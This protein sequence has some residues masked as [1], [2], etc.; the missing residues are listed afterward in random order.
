MN[1]LSNKSA[2]SSEISLMDPLYVFTYPGGPLTLFSM[3]PLVKHEAKKR[4][5][6]TGIASESSR[7]GGRGMGKG[8]ISGPNNSPYYNSFSPY[9]EK[10]GL[11]TIT[12]D[13]KLQRKKVIANYYLIV[14][15]FI[16]PDC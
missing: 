16:I 13:V 3:M 12:F 1:R 7:A 9:L 5:N 11:T 15:L 6:A 8:I 10:M 14:S 2:R 4:A